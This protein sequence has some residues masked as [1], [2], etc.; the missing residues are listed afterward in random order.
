[1]PHPSRLIAGMARQANLSAL[2][3]M[4]GAAR[5]GSESAPYL[6]DLAGDLTSL[7][8]S[9]AKATKEMTEQVKGTSGGDIAATLAAMRDAAVGVTDALRQ[10]TDTTAAKRSDADPTQPFAS[11]G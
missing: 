8:S 9:A 7:A 1:M 2:D 6:A 11:N 3:A 4:I 10:R 5:A